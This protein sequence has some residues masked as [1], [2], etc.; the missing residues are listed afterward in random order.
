MTDPTGMARRTGRKVQNALSSLDLA[1]LPPQTRPTARG[2]VQYRGFRS[3]DAF[4]GDTESVLVPLDVELHLC[5]DEFDECGGLLLFGLW[6]A[7]D[8]HC[9]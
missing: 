4:E 8:Q 1:P 6:D 2:R 7:R 3:V 9:P 5:F